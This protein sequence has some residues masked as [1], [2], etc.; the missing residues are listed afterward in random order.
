MSGKIDHRRR[1]FVGT[2]AAGAVAQLVGSGPAGAWP[3]KENPVKR[4]VA[5]SQPESI[6]ASLARATEWLNSRPLSAE[7]LRGKVVLV[8]FWTYTCINWLRTLA[9]VRAW[10][11]K[12]ESSGLAVIGVHSPEFVFERNVGNV[13]QAASDLRVGYPV[14]IDSDHAIWR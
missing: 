5:Q 11:N 1:Q 9:Y 12:Y 4:F 2:L 7:S 10:A 3:I 6:L 13:R 14:A 8:Q